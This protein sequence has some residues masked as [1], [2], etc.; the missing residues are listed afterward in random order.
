MLNKKA[1]PKRRVV[2]D[3]VLS[4][5]KPLVINRSMPFLDIDGANTTERA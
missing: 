3:V 5:E 4:L 1:S 2:V